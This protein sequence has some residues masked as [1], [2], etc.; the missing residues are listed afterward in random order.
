MFILKK[1]I[2]FAALCTDFSEGVKIGISILRE[3]QK[4]INEF[5]EVPVMEREIN[6]NYSGA[7]MNKKNQKNN[8]L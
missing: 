3:S 4:V 2:N 8:I 5:L 6:S 7:F 1:C